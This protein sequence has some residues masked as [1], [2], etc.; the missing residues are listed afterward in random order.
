MV[1]GGQADQRG[2]IVDDDPAILEADEGDEEANSAG[3]GQFEFLGNGLQ[4]ALA[5]ARQTQDQKQDAPVKHQSEGRLPWN[6]R[7]EANAE[8]EESIETHAR[9]QRDGIVGGQGHG[10]GH[11]GRSECSGGDQG[12]LIHPTHPENRRVDCQDVGHGSESG[13]AGN[14][15][16]ADRAA[17]MGQLKPTFNHEGEVFRGLGK[18]PS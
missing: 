6:F 4:Q 18:L 9:S 11:D 7:T 17:V 8:S 1:E 16:L 10:E 13:D 3:D 14:D 5:D 15:L 2:R 12:S